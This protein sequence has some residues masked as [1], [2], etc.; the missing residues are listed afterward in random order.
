M[1]RIQLF[2]VQ[3]LQDAIQIL[4]A[5]TKVYIRKNPL[6]SSVLA[7]QL[8]SNLRGSEQCR[9]HSSWV[10][11]SLPKGLPFAAFLQSGISSQEL[12]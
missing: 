11:H 1:L 12:Q 8:F 10:S 7:N 2:N 6:D 5:S 4:A 3:R 9:S